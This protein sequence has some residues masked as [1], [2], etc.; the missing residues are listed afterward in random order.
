[1]HFTTGTTPTTVDTVW[2]L[3]ARILIRLSKITGDVRHLPSIN[4]SKRQLIEKAYKT[5]ILQ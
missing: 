5:L 3:W 2:S 4:D 1:M